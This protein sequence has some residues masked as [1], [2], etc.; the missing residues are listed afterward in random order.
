M[1]A[2]KY[3]DAFFAANIPANRWSVTQ[4]AVNTQFA[5]LHILSAKWTTLHC[6]L[7]PTSRNNTEEEQGVYMIIVISNA[8]A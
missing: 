8:C 3:R 6:T 1:K 2:T 5:T 7:S 4:E